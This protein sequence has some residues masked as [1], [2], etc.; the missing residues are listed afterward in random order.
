MA[1]NPA[2]ADSTQ[3]S[4]SLDPIIHSQQVLINH[5]LDRIESLER[6]VS[7]LERAR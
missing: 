6:R 3:K 2:E 7:T 4:Y 1:V 5:L